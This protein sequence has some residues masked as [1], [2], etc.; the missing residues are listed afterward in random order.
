MGN[1]S[2]ATIHSIRISTFCQLYLLHYHIHTATNVVQAHSSPS[3]NCLSA[4]WALVQLNLP[5]WIFPLCWKGHL[6]VH[7]QTVQVQVLTPLALDNQSSIRTRSHTHMCCLQCQKPCCN[8]LSFLSNP[9]TN[10]CRRVSRTRT[11]H[12]ISTSTNTNNNTRCNS[13][14][15]YHS[16]HHSH[17]MSQ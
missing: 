11:T 15:Y 17:S 1:L 6:Q 14:I 4:V 10:Q 2:L 13:S 8:L 3:A 16:M 9:A 5:R 12:I 7:L